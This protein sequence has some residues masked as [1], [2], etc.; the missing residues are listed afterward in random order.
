MRAV[1]CHDVTGF[2]REVACIVKGRML[3]IKVVERLFRAKAMFPV[4]RQATY[5]AGVAI[6]VADRRRAWIG[7]KLIHCPGTETLSLCISRSDVF[8]RPSP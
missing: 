2:G 4:S 7:G 1:C 6:V 3:R 8:H 5:G